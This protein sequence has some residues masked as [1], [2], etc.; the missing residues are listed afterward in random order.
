V[1]GSVGGIVSIEHHG[2]IEF[3]ARGNA[4]EYGLARFEV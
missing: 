1:K 2:M 3:A 4:E